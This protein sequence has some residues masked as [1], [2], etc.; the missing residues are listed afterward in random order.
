M[1]M[2]FFRG[3]FSLLCVSYQYCSDGKLVEKNENR[4]R[5]STKN[6]KCLLKIHQHRDFL[7]IF[8][9][10]IKHHFYFLFYYFAAMS[11]VLI[12]ALLGD[13]QIVNI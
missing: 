6:K 12:C 8:V 13:T 2:I 7:H 4:N 3:T 10:F 11:F 9:R 5:D 1:M